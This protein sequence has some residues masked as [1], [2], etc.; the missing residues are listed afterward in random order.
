MRGALLRASALEPMR[1]LAASSHFRAGALDM[2]PACLALTPFGLVCGIDAAAAGADWISAL[3][4]SAIIFSG[5]AQVLSAQLIAADAPV[6]VIV[7]TC[8]VAGLRFLMYSAAMAPWLKPLPPRWQRALPFLLTDQAFAVA[9]RRFSSEND[10][11]S[12]ALYFLG[13]GLALWS[14]WQVQ[15]MLG[16][17]AG[18]VV[19]AGWSLDFAVPLC[20]I[21]LVG[22]LLRSAPVIVAAIVGGVA[23]VA[24]DGLPMKLNLIAAGL[25]GIAAGT[26]ADL[27]RERWPLR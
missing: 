9:I 23:V 26:L 20:F 2:L 22:P 5:A 25:A 1:H 10:P 13:S 11:R 3:A 12:G 19:P 24:L 8:F 7:L 16:Y 14:A 18:H 27:A 6:A 15:N 4:M 21:A 17:F